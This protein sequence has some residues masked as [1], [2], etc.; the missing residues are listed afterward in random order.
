MIALRQ[1]GFVT[2]ASVALGR[3]GRSASLVGNSSSD[4]VRDTAL[5]DPEPGN[6]E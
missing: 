5:L 1:I 4:K 3:C 2:Y 6:I